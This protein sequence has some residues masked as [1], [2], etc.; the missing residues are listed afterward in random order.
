MKNGCG[1][2]SFSARVLSP[3]CPRRSLCPG[4][5]HGG[6][7]GGE[8]KQ[9]WARIRMSINNTANVLYM[10]CRKRV[11]SNA[12]EGCGTIRTLELEQLVYDS[13]VVK[14]REFN[15]KVKHFLV[16]SRVS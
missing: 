16:L 10:R 2:F 5:A 8:P 6:M 11:E 12:C 13:M 3:S 4:A 15:A 7:V 1:V 9:K 14:L